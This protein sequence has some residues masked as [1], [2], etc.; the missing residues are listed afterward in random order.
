[1]SIALDALCLMVL[2]EKPTAVVLSIWMGVGGCGCP[3]SSK[4]TRIGKISLAHRNPAPI[5]ASAADPITHL[6]ILQITCMG[7]L[8]GTSANGA[9]G[10]GLSLRKKCAPARL[11]ALGAERYEAS[12]CVWRHISLA[13]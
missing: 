9:G 11:L 8:I 13:I 7:P 12:L 10:A 5:S 2:L 3:I 4:H 6:I 1:M